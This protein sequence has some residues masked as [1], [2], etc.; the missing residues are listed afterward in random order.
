MPPLSLG[1]H[2]C[3]FRRL[4]LSPVKVL[5]SLT[6]HVVTE[7][8]SERG[9]EEA[10]LEGPTLVHRGHPG[11]ARTGCPQLDHTQD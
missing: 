11:A 9:L 10:K 4:I 2:T 3:K 1:L 7:Y 8:K 5:P 6:V